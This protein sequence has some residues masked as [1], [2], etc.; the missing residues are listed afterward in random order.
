MASQFSIQR[1]FE[2]ILSFQ[3]GV[4][5]PH[6]Y[7]VAVPKPVAVPVPAPVA[8]PIIKSYASA[9]IVHDYHGHGLGH[10]LAHSLHSKLGW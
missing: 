9:P 4:P 5:V 8:V 1:C 3:V 2:R 10:G 7:P 6:P